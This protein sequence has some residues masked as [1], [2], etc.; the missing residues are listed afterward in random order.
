MTALSPTVGARHDM[1]GMRLDYL[2]PKT[3]LRDIVERARSGQGGYCCVANVH[4]CVLAHDDTGFAAQV[5]GATYVIA[6]STI[7]Q[8]A[9]SLRHGVAF[10]ETMRGAEMMLALAERAAAQGV[11]IGLIGGKDDAILLRL[12]HKLFER[13]P[14][15]DIAFAY[16]PPF[17]GMSQQ[18]D[19]ALIANIVASGAQLIFVGLGCPKQERW[20]A[21]HTD[22]LDAMMVG[23][24]AAFDFNAGVVETSPS[25]VHKAGLEWLYR[26]IKEPRRLWRRYLG[27][28]PRFLW[29]MVW[30]RLGSGA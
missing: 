15:L 5:N 24:G 27:T 20:M 29:L 14:G 30:D 16:S 21:A 12:Q 10:K 23:I 1:L 8:R 4:M 7:L 11:K 17:S 22:R 3:Y 26:L 9:R 6:D 18:A 2:E 28:S 25:W 13:M 19:D